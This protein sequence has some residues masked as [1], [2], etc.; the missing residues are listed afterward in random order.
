M[1][2]QVLYAGCESIQ[3]NKKSD[4]SAYGPFYKMYYLAPVQIVA[5]ANRK[6]DGGG[7]SPQEVSI[8]AAIFHNIKNFQGLS[9]VNVDSGADPLNLNRTVVSSVVLVKSI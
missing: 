2:I 9:K 4:G 7:F 3:G 6:I 1:S 5:Q 8:D